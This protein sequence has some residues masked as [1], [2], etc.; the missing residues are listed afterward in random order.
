MS[1]LLHIDVSPRG[2]HSVSRTLSAAFAETWKSKHADG[3][4]TYRD[5][6]AAEIPFVDLPWIMGAYSAPETHSPE[7]KNALAVSDKFIGELL[8]ADEIVIGTPMYNFAVPARLKAWIDH[9][10]RHGKTFTVGASGY[11]GLA[12][13]RKATVI[14]ASAGSYLPGAPAASYNNEGPYLTSIFGFMG[15]TDVNIVLS[16]DTAGVA[17]GKVDMGEY[18]KPHLEQV[19]AAVV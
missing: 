14:I 7:M 4:V 12:G 10:V 15:I 5:L 8:A 3:N 11:E 18:L 9:V 2:D 16:G 6:A 1:H 17:Q 19:R 13:G